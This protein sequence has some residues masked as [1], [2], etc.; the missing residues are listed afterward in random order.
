[1]YNLGDT[2]W[3]VFDFGERFWGCKFCDILK[4]NALWGSVLIII[5]CSIKSNIAVCIGLVMCSGFTLVLLLA[6]L[7]CVLILIIILIEKL[8]SYTERVLFG[9]N[10]IFK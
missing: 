4:L 1:M 2:I 3:R 6:S 5:G 9:K 7:F 10:R 8:L